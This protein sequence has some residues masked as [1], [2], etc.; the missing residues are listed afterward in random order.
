[1]F[2]C[3]FAY[4]TLNFKNEYFITGLQWRHWPTIYGGQTIIELPAIH[5]ILDNSLN[6]SFLIPVIHYKKTT[7][8]EC[9]KEAI[10]IIESRTITITPPDKAIICFGIALE[11]E[12]WDIVG[13]TSVGSSR[14]I[15]IATECQLDDKESY[16]YVPIHY[17]EGNFDKIKKETKELINT[18]ISGHK[19]LAF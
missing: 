2:E 15:K 12:R 7:L 5:V 8:E 3:I 19:E 9:G 18:V 16:N 10:G 6:K 11:N 17:I 4:T 13:M 14:L 1:M